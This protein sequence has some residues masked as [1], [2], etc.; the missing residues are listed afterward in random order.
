VATPRERCIDALLD[1]LVGAQVDLEHLYA[2][3][4]QSWVT[5]GA[6]HP[7]ASAREKEGCRSADARRGPGD[8]NI[9]LR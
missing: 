2:A 9:E 8:K 7:C 5:T 4:S 3:H 1:G 6:Q